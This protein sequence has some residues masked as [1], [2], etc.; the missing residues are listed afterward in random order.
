MMRHIRSFSKGPPS[1]RRGPS[2][3]ADRVFFQGGGVSVDSWTPGPNADAIGIQ[4]VH[5]RVDSCGLVWTPGVPGGAGPPDGRRSTHPASALSQEPLGGPPAD[6]V[7]ERRIE[8]R[9]V[10][11]QLGDGARIGAIVVG[12]VGAPEDAAVDA[13]LPEPRQA[14]RLVR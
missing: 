13:H 4:P 10:L 12:V 7:G 8:R 5:T 6:A 11:L 1:P 3:T 2:G 14:I 9:Q